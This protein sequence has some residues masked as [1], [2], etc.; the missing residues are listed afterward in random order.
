MGRNIKTAKVFYVE[1]DSK[2]MEELLNVTTEDLTVFKDFPL[3]KAS[4]FFRGENIS[5]IPKSSLI[6]AVMKDAVKQNIKT[7]TE[8]SKYLPSGFAKVTLWLAPLKD[9]GFGE[10]VYGTCTPP[11]LFGNKTA[12]VINNYGLDKPKFKN[13]PHLFNTQLQKLLPKVDYC[14]PLKVSKKKVRRPQRNRKNELALFRDILIIREA[15]LDDQKRE[16]VTD[17]TSKRHGGNASFTVK[18]FGATAILTSDSSVVAWG[19]T[20]YGGNTSQVQAQLRVDVQAIYSN[21]KAFAALKADSSVVSWGNP[22]S[23]MKAASEPLANLQENGVVQSIFQNILAIAALRADGGVFALGDSVSGGDCSHVQRQL[24]DVQAIYS[25]DEAFAALKVDD[26]VAWGDDKAQAK[27]VSGPLAKLQEDGVVQSI[28]QTDAA[29]AAL[30]ADSS[31]VTWGAKDSGGDCSN[32][33]LQLAVDVQAIYHNH[34]AFAAL[35][36]DGGVVSWGSGGVIKDLVGRITG[37]FDLGFSRVQQQ[38]AVDA[39]AIYHTDYAFAA[40]KADCSVVAWGSSEYGGRAPFLVDVQSI[41][42][43]EKAFAALKANGG[44]V[45]WGAWGGDT[46]QVQD[47]LVDVQDIYST[48]SA[49]AAL[50]ADGSVVAWGYLHEGGDCSTVQAQIMVDVQDIYHTDYAFAALKA[51]G[52]VVSWGSGGV[53]K[54]PDGHITGESDLGFSRVQQQLAVDVQTIYYTNEAFAA[55][56]ADTSV[57]SWGM[58]SERAAILAHSR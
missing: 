24:V 48:S 17:V 51:D 15:I 54:G 13:D 32:V 16:G 25:S 57:V 29:I 43:N 10:G 56:K 23:Q 58:N 38:L 42:H 19:D 1:A 21:D 55:L 53:I 31:V 33:Q 35:K 8:L 41:Y 20:E 4:V 27:A 37:E 28:S 46:S 34:R 47:Q 45:A 30:K 18:N 26:V 39:Q 5:K 40:L 49:F 3:G 52:G 22:G 36:A 2:L 44:V 50:K 6:F 7:K 14:I 11:H 9:S 12:I